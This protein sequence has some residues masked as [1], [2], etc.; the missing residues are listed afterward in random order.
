M[1]IDMINYVKTS[2]LKLNNKVK[3]LTSWGFPI[4]GTAEINGVVIWDKKDMCFCIDGI[5]AGCDRCFPLHDCWDFEKL[6]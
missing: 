1:S 3:A 2:E 5:I 4:Q 6:E